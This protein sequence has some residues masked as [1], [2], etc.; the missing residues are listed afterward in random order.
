[1]LT[2]TVYYCERTQMQ[3]GKGKMLTKQ[4]PQESQVQFPALPLSEVMQ[5]AV[6]V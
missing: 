3:A 4:S 6:V 2:A 5:M 1:M